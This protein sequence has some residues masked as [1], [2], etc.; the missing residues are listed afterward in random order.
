MCGTTQLDAA[1]CSSKRYQHLAETGTIM[2]TYRHNILYK[3]LNMFRGEMYAYYICMQLHLLQH[4]TQFMAQDIVCK[5]FPY[6]QRCARQN[7]SDEALQSISKQKPF[8]S[9]LHAHAHSWFC[10]VTTI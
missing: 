6:L 3:A 2:A 8:L 7:P 10:Q 5:Y 9:V 1:K 4:N